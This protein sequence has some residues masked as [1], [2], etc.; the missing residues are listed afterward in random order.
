MRFQVEDAESERAGEA[1]GGWEADL[2][3]YSGSNS[4]KPSLGLASLLPFR[5]PSR[6]PSS[7][8]PC[9]GEMRKL[10]GLWLSG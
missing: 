1:A 9:P 5:L 2:N 3:P 10:G 7:L 6:F 4:G 8:R